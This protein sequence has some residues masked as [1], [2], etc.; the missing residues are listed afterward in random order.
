[1]AQFDEAITLLREVINTKDWH[2]YY[3]LLLSKNLFLEE[4]CGTA[5]LN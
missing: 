3:L 2:I 5:K 1:M 4:K